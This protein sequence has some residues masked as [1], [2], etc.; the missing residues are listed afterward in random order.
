M[1]IRSAFLLLLLSIS[2]VALAQA[3]RL[4]LA[5]AEELAM[6][7][8]PR[9]ASAA[10]IAAA[11]RMGITEARAPFNPQV[12]GAVTGVAAEHGSTLAAGTIQTS[13]LY[14]RIAAG[15][16]VSQLITDF[17]RTG[18]LVASAKARAAAQDRNA[19]NVRSSI[20]IVVDQAYY[21]ALAAASVLKVA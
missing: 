4:T 16:T 14:S 18:N 15:V 6:H 8:H 2:D 20:R 3:K 10:L 21:E 17:G 11:S 19:E 9:A 12:S 7:G 1:R 13:S 5:E